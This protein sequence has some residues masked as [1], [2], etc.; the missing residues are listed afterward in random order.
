MLNSNQLEDFAEIE[1]THAVLAAAY[2][3]FTTEEKKYLGQTRLMNLVAFT[4]D[5]LEFP[6]TRG[7]YR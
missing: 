1:F 5:I 4:A 6:L 7:W 3:V 2:E